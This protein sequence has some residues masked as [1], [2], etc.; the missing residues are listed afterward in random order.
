M[1]MMSKTDDVDG[2][3]TKEGGERFVLVWALGV[4]TRERREGLAQ[5]C[6]TDLWHKRSGQ[7]LRFCV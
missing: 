6:G 3:Q 1:W 7:W 4:R 2:E 5:C